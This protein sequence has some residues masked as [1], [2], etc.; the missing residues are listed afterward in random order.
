M[1]YFFKG[2]IF[3]TGAVLFAQEEDSIEDQTRFNSQF[4]NSSALVGLEAGLIGGAIAA[5]LLNHSGNTGLT[6]LTGATGLTGI[7]D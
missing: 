1:N 6:G 3:F 2:I 5:E 4:V 7:Q